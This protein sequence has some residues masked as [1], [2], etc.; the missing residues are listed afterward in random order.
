MLQQ[1]RS[2]RSRKQILDK[3]LRLF[4]KQG[5]RG[6]NIRE[7]ADSRAGCVIGKACEA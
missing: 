4:S 6:T 1:D 5:Y 7:I 3:A 2:D